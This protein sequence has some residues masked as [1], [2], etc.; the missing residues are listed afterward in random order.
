L[1]A[2]NHVSDVVFVDLEHGTVYC[3]RAC[4]EHDYFDRGYGATAPGVSR[5]DDA[6]D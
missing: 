4:A 5:W 3:C 2:P 1:G 6:E